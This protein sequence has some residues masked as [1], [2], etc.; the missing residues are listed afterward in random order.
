MTTLADFLAD[1][2]IPPK[3]SPDDTSTPLERV[4]RAVVGSLT[5]KERKV[6]DERM[7]SAQER[8]VRSAAATLSE[9]QKELLAERFP[10]IADPAD[11]LWAAVC[12]NR[13]AKKRGA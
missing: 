13:E 12:A 9:R 4:T 6:L 5:D 1:R 2:L 10:D 11:R 3:T 8:I 7:S